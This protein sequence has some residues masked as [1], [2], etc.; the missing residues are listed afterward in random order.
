MNRKLY[1]LGILLI[2]SA[3]TFAQTS[4]IFIKIR[5]SVLEKP[6]MATEA[7]LNCKVK[8]A[9][10]IMENPE[11]SECFRIIPYQ[12]IGTVITTRRPAKAT[13]KPLSNGPKES[14][15]VIYVSSE[16]QPMGLTAGKKIEHLGGG[17]LP[18]SQAPAGSYQSFYS[19][20]QNP[21]TI[22]K[23]VH[24]SAYTRA[25][26]TY[27]SAHYRSAPGAKNR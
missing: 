16:Q 24:V 15:G 8:P 1:V 26:G 5:K 17:P 19:S 3:A 20:G 10:S 6:K 21:I 25:D 7:A 14:I 22:S 11:G 2:I 18:V 9:S 4:S 13:V 23:T 12:G 27:V